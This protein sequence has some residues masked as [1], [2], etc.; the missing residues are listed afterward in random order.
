VFQGLEHGRHFLS[1]RARL[2]TMNESGNSAHT[3]FPP[4]GLVAGCYQLATSNE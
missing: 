2:T 4:E 3:R 1:D